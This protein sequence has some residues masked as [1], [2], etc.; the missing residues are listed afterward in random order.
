MRIASFCPALL[1]KWF[2][3]LRT[4]RLTRSAGTT[5]LSTHELCFRKCSRLRVISG[6]GFVRRALS[7]AWSLSII[8]G[9]LGA[10]RSSALDEV[11]GFRQIWGEDLEFT[12]RLQGARK[13][14]VFDPSPIVRAEC[15]ADLRSLWR[16]RVR[17]VRS[18]LKVSAIHSELFLPARAF[19]FSLYLPFNYFALAIVPLLQIVAAPFLIRLAFTSSSGLDWIW[20][21]LMYC[22]L[23]TFGI[24]AVYS[25]MLDRDFRTLM[26]VPVAMVLIVPLSFFYSCV[27]LSSVWQERMGRVERWE[28]IERLPSAALAGRSGLSLLIGGILLLSGIGRPAYHAR[29]RDCLH[30]L[31][32]D[33]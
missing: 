25:I 23:L 4:Q 17:W 24:V 32:L 8:S 29:P 21:I 10:V 28:K 5:P 6:T 11:Q 12:F 22:G 7:S 20:S 30:R 19:P 18:Y 33:L 13:R 9:N 14:I 2:G 26:Y 27:V 15:P 31:I 1:R 16:Q 3:G